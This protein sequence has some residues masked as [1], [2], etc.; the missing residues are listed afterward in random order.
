MLGL[1]YH[2]TYFQVVIHVAAGDGR[3]AGRS[4]DL[5]PVTGNATQSHARVLGPVHVT[6]NGGMMVFTLY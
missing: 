1:I 2:V 5:V 6:E 4:A 3:E